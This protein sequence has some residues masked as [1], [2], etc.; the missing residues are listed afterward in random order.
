MP[1]TRRALTATML[2]AAMPAARG[3]GFPAHTVRVVVPYAPGGGTDI[4]ARIMAQHATAESGQSFA[5]EN[6][7]GG[8]S[9]PGTQAVVSAAPDGHTIGMMDLSLVTNPGLFGSR[10]PYDTERDITAVGAVAATPPALLA[11]P[12]TGARALA[13]FLA[14]SRAKP[15]ALAF[16]HAGNGTASH[17]AAAQLQMAAGLRLSLV[18][19]RGA[20]P[21][22]AA[23]AAGETPFGFGAV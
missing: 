15:G 1:A 5:V 10:L 16:A 4:V 2:A 9:V 20:G 17:L 8:A 3:A 18:A 7:S 6:R 13:D 21:A 23:M 14:Q 11:H 19:Y 22:A 12:S